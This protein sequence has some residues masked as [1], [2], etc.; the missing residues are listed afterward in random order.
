[1]SFSVNGCTYE[2]YI[3]VL[4]KIT[5]QNLNMNTR[6]TK[7]ARHNKNSKIKDTRNN[8]VKRR[9]KSRCFNCRLRMGECETNYTDAILLQPQ[10]FRDVLN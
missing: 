9:D 8:I 7:I 1:M 4:N 3:K 2:F 10:G 5:R 6:K